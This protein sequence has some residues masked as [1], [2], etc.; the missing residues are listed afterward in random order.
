MRNVFIGLFALGFARAVFDANRAPQTPP[1]ERKNAGRNADQ[2]YSF[3]E[4]ESG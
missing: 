4:R 2:T 3:A 1:T